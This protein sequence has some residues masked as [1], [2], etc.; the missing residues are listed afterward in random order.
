MRKKTYWLARSSA[1]YELYLSVKPPKARGT[2]FVGPGRIFFAFP[3]RFHAISKIRL[4]KQQYVRLTGTF[5]FERTD[6]CGIE[7]IESEG[8]E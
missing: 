7:L 4:R 8:E 6:K 3:Y 1:G 5:G 2:I